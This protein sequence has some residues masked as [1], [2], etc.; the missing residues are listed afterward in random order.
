MKCLMA[1]SRQLLESQQTE[2]GSMAMNEIGDKRCQVGCE[3]RSTDVTN[4]VL[5]LGTQLLCRL[6]LKQSQ[7]AMLIRHSQSCT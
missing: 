6:Q 7:R 5:A 3:G 4:S 1:H 2:A